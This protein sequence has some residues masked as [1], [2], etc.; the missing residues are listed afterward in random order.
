MK[1][2]TVASGKGGTGKTTLSALLAHLSASSIRIAVADADVEA[3]NLPLALGFA[4]ERSEVF[5][6]GL[7]AS[8]DPGRCMGCGACA[9]ACRF[10]AISSTDDV[11]RVDTIACEGCTTCAFV[12][13]V[14]AVT[15]SRDI[16]GSVS[17]GVSAVGP[18]AFG[19]LRPGHDLSGKLVTEVRSRASALAAAHGAELLLIDGPPGT[20]CPAIASATG[21][22]MVLAVAE[23]TYSGAHDLG[24]LES[25]VTHLDV[26]MAAVLNKADLSSAGAERVRDLCAERCVPLVAEIPYDPALRDAMA[27]M[28]EGRAVADTA[29]GRST[30]H[31]VA[32][33]WEWLRAALLSGP[34]LS[35]GSWATDALEVGYDPRD[36]TL[37]R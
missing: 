25:L 15:F 27:R 6:G 14:D 29:I 16:A 7:T 30:A 20:G 35:V 22:D 13:A 34:S 33:V 3:S 10:G 4:H 17:T 37:D 23:P 28:A 36:S 26:P 5:E 31:A 32:T 2:I 21:T 24:R 19:Q 9:A 12:C 1:T 18:L 11:Y 8:I